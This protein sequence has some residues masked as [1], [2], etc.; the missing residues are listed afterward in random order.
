MLLYRGVIHKPIYHMYYTNEKYLKQP[1]AEKLF[2]RIKSYLLG[3]TSTLSIYQNLVKAIIVHPKFIQYTN[4]LL[5][6]GNHF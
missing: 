1:A 3:N 5:S 2:P 6:A 4:V